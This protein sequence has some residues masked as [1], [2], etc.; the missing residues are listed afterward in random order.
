MQL[1]SEILSDITVHMKYARYLTDKYRRE[2]IECLTALICLLMIFGHLAKQCFF[3]WA[4]QV[5]DIQFR[6]I[7]SRTYQKSLNLVVSEHIAI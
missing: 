1:S 2:T 3:F 6:P 5:L 7:T 4:A